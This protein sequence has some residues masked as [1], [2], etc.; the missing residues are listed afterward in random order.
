MKKPPITVRVYAV[1]VFIPHY[2]LAII[3]RDKTRIKLYGLLIKLT[4]KG[5]FEIKENEE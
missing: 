5:R 3:R 2:I 1:L 4:A